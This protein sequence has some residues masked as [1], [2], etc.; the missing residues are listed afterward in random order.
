M[1]GDGWTIEGQYFETCNCEYLCPCV[2]SN[3]TARPDEGD[4]AVALAFRI[5]RGG[6]GGVP[7]DGLAFIVVARSSGPMADG[8]WTVGLVV[9]E[10]ASQEQADAILAI[11]SGQAGGPMAAVAPLIGAF[12]GVERRPI[13]FEAAGMRYAVTAGELVDQACEGVASPAAP[14]QPIVLDNAFHPANTRLALAKATR[15]RFDA[16]GI[17]WSDTSGTRNGHFAPFRW[18]A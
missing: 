9:D 10:R 1:A 17:G 12:A 3:M 11:A 4:C 15:S 5:D 14:G 2:S 8:G 18:T 13:R 6:R 16:F 7:L